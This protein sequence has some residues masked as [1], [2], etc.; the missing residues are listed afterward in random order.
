MVVGGWCL[1]GVVVRVVGER[2]RGSGGARV[3]RCFSRSLERSDVVVVE[4]HCFKSVKAVV[5]GVVVGLDFCSEQVV[6]RT[7]L[8]NLF[9]Q[10]TLLKTCFH[11]SCSA[12]DREL[13]DTNETDTVST[14]DK[15]RL[16]ANR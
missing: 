16:G 9:G 5:D 2:C 3:H 13:S 15:S 7:H 11:H 8:V 14:I 6:K 10:G 4:H 12:E 1:G